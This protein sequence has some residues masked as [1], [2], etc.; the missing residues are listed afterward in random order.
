MMF[1]T[2]N[3]LGSE[4]VA[5]SDIAAFAIQSVIDDA[6]L[7]PGPDIPRKIELPLEGN[8]KTVFTASNGD[9]SVLPDF[10][11]QAVKLTIVESSDIQLLPDF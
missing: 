1:A 7:V 5:V 10:C 8:G 4:N 6:E 3:E 11:R 2:P 9:T